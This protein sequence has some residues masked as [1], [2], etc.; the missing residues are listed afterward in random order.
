MAQVPTG[1][2]P[3][4]GPQTCASHTGHVRQSPTAQA[5]SL[6]AKPFRIAYLGRKKYCASCMKRKTGWVVTW[7]V[8]KARQ[9]GVCMDSDTRRLVEGW[10]EKFWS[11]NRL[12]Q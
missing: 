9:C 3:S 11:H 10:F 5:A 12:N 4:E 7:G 1:H 8:V 2:S 6:P